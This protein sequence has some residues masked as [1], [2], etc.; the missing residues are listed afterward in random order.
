MRVGKNVSLRT[1]R[2][3]DVAYLVKS[4]ESEEIRFMTNTAQA[5]TRDVIEKHIKRISKDDERYDF[6]I[7]HNESK[8]MI[9]ECSVLEIDEDNDSERFRIAMSTIE[10]TGKRYGS[11]AM[12]LIIDFVFDELKLNR[13]HFEVFNFNKRGIKAYK[14]VGF[15]EEGRLR[16]AIKVNGEDH[17]ETI[18]SIIKEDLV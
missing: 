15:I 10:H 18:M 7:I 2:V 5:F 11:E 16:Q 12:N 6:A 17:D 3:E 4:S 1:L 8:E 14:K 13:L 9:G